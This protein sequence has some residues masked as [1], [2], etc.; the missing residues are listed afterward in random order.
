MLLQV[1][2]FRFDLELRDCEHRLMWV[3]CDCVR[4]EVY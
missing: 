1:I 3:E 4:C 2:S